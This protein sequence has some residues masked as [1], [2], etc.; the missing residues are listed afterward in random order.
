M[1]RKLVILL[2]SVAV[3]SLGMIL[4]ARLLPP[5]SVTGHL[6]QEDLHRIQQAIRRSM[7]ANV[8]P[9][10]SWHSIRQ[11]ARQFALWGTGRVHKIEILG[12][13][14][15]QVQVRSLSGEQWYLLD[16]RHDEKGNWN[17]RVAGQG[18]HRVAYVEE[19]DQG[20]LGARAPFGPLDIETPSFSVSRA[21]HEWTNS[22]FSPTPDH[23]FSMFLS[24]R[25]KLT[26]HH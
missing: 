7:R 15:V 21:P 22:P 2:F 26:L 6:P 18:S 24:N 10:A 8:L 16:E 1:K 3:I 12:R 20:P 14:S 17:W 23:D 9:S 4:G 19:V 13:T 11:S 5:A 25:A